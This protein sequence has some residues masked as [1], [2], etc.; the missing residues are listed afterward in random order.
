MTKLF[1]PVTLLS[2]GEFGSLSLREA[3][4]DRVALPRS[5]YF[6]TFGGEGRGALGGSVGRAS[7]SRFDD[8]RFEPRPEHNTLKKK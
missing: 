2:Q 4:C 3:S 7:D 1:L 6:L 5:N 8:P